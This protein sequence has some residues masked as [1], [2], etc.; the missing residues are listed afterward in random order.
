MIEDVMQA[1]LPKFVTAVRITDLAQGRNPLRIVAMR[2]L[3][4]QQGRRLK[5]GDDWIDQGKDVR[6]VDIR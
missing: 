5:N 2:G 3:P 6:D 1:S 4:D